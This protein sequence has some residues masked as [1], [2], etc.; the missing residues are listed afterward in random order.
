MDFNTLIQEC[1]EELQV[2]GLDSRNIYDTIVMLTE[3]CLLAFSERGR[4]FENLKLEH[5]G[6]VIHDLIMEDLDIDS[7]LS[8]SID[9]LLKASWDIRLSSI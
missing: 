7:I 8:I 1:S 3:K 6:T 4:D 5:I 2:R 9:D